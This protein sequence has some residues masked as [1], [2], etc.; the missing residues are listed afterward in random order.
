MFI[1]VEFMNFPPKNDLNPRRSPMQACTACSLQAP[2]F[3][4]ISPRH[5]KVCSRQRSPI[6]PSTM[7]RPWGDR[8]VW[9]EL[10]SSAGKRKRKRKREREKKTS[11]PSCALAAKNK[12]VI[13][14][15]KK[16]TRLLAHKATLR[17]GGGVGW[18]EWAELRA[19]AF[20]WLI[21]TGWDQLGFKSDATSVLLPPCRRAVDKPTCLS[22][23]KVMQ[24]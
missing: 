1:Y 14:K 17:D 21:F 15:E 5:M 12:L 20:V 8:R 10:Q 4:E 24:V 6:S 2:S 16:G 13:E 11:A 3:I 7:Q 22:D 9:T 23:T 19:W 18:G